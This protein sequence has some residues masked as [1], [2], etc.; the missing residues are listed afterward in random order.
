MNF[1]KTNINKII[2]F[3]HIVSTIKK[4]M[5]GRGSKI[6]LGHFQSW[7]FYS[8]QSTKCFEQALGGKVYAF[9]R[10]HPIVV[11]LCGLEHFY[12]R[13]MSSVILLAGSFSGI[14]CLQ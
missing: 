12:D 14:H 2:F 5:G 1:K 6:N 11:K 9:P 7:K 13:I 3:Y 4:N 8:E 10:P